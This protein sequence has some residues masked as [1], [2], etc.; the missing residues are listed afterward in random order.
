M[1]GGEALCIY[2]L[3]VFH[4]QNL[5]I[6]RGRQR[7]LAVQLVQ[8]GEQP[9]KHNPGLSSPVVHLS[10]ACCCFPVDRFYGNVFSVWL[11]HK[12]NVLI[13]GGIAFNLV[14][15]LIDYLEGKMLRHINAKSINSRWHGFL[16]FVIV[17]LF[18]FFFPP[19]ISQ[20]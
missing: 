6:M 2:S 13:E 5:L 12:N 17:T 16:L 15:Q 4:L 1:G 18:A 8:N 14:H 7:A 11:P 3:V 19:N 10:S 20:F 9:L